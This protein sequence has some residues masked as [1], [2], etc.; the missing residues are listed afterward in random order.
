LETRKA[1][2]RA[3]Q[4]VWCAFSIHRASSFLQIKNGKPKSK[5]K[6]SSGA[7]SVAK[8]RWAVNVRAVQ[9]GGHLNFDF[10]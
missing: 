2:L 5:I 9:S 4:T 6:N 7:R 8:R 10:T 1:Q 3:R